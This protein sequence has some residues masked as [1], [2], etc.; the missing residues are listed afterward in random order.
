MKTLKNNWRFIT[1]MSLII[2]MGTLAT[3]FSYALASSLQN[4]S[5]NVYPPYPRNEYGL[6]YGSAAFANSIEAEPDLISVEGEDG[7]R[8]YVYA[9]DLREPMPR[10]P[11]EA[12]EQMKHAREPRSVII[13]EEDGKTAIGVFVVGGGEGVP[14][15]GKYPR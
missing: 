1:I 3:L 15:D 7:V 4:D 8:G 12:I 11:E 2:I 9:T 10:N 5:E 6:T 14:A 13:Y